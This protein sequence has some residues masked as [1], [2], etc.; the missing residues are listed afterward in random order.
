MKLC[1]VVFASLV[2]LACQT[3]PKRIVLAPPSPTQV[4]LVEPDRAEADEQ[5]TDRE[6]S[7]GEAVE[8]YLLKRT[9][10]A[11]LPAEKVLSARRHAALMPSYSVSAGRFVS[12]RAKNAGSRE[13]GLGT[14]QP[15]GPG[16][17]GG[18]TRALVIRP[19]D[20]NTMYA[21]SVGGGVWKTT[22]GGASW[23]PLTDLLP[24][25]GIG[26]LVMDPKNPD[27]L[28]AGTGEWFT[29]STRGDSIRGAGIYKTTDGGATWTLLPFTADN[30][31][32]YYVNKLVISPNDSQHVYAATYGGIWYSANAGTSW[33]RVLDRSGVAYGCQDLVTRTDQTTDYLFAGCGVRGGINP[34][35]YRN[36][37]AAGSGTWQIVFT[38][39]NMA[40]AVLGLAPSNQSIIYAAIVS[41][42]T[43]EYSN[44]LLGVYRSDSN[45]DPDS[46]TMKTSNQDA[47]LLNRV[48][49]S[50][51]RDFFTDVCSNGPRTFSNQGEYDN[52]IAVDPTNPDIVWVGGIDLFRS[53][54]GGANWGIAAFWEAAAPFL[55]HADN[56]AIVFAPGYNGADNQTLFAASDGG[57]Y[58]TDN[59]LAATAK[60]PRAACTPYSSQIIWQN[61]NNG[62]AVTQ[63]YHGSVYPG[64][65]VYVGGTQD[66]GTVRGSD[67]AGPNDW[68]NPI[69]G[70]GGVTAIDP[71]DPNVWYGETTRLTLRKTVNGGGTFATATRGITE[72]STNFQFI[73]PFVIDPS[74]PKRLYLG[75][76]TLWRTSDA[77]ANWSE[78][79][80]PISTAAGSISTIAVSGADPNHVVFGTSTGFIY[81]N[82]AALTADKTT[83]WQPVQPRT[84]YVSNLAFD[85]KDPNL[86]YATYS[87]YKTGSQN[88]V[89]KSTDGGATWTGLDGSG[90]TA[91]P[92]IPVFSIIVDPKNTANL[93]LG[94]DIGV[95]VSVDGG[96]TWARDDNPFA[97]AVTETLVLDH[98]TGQSVLVAF[99]HGRGVWKTVLPGSGDPCQVSLSGDSFAFPALGGTATF[100]VTAPDNCPWS[101]V[102]GGTGFTISSPAG[103]KGNGSF[104]I[105]APRNATT[106]GRSAKVSVQTGGIAVTQDAA[107][108]ASGNDVMA[109]PFAITGPPA[110]VI[111]NTSSATETTGDPVHTCTQSADS[112][113]LWFRVTAAD[114]GSLQLGFLNSRLDTGTDAGTVLTA[115][116]LVSGARGAEAVCSVTPQSN[117]VLTIRTPALSVQ[118][119]ESVLIE[120]SAT[121]F[122]A[123]AGAPVR[124][125]NLQLLLNL[126]K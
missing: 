12:P 45:G 101:A 87:Q 99:T 93:Y 5:E 54:D 56:H 117:S 57:V 120:V 53:D 124:P 18:R 21:G 94:T 81:R 38:S 42:E 63:F 116:R 89:Y 51:P 113:T 106:Q 78:A 108:A 84:G 16:N 104:T 123:P 37:D 13:A 73:T 32:F 103:G 105:T 35:I 27:T 10:G 30:S 122:N 1:V 2:L 97:D 22:D 43:G 33:R 126:V 15:L 24:S 40:D 64:G 69:G 125:G 60:G 34:G 118:A 55:S 92:D 20:P 85:P 59:A 71:T 26:S 111:E 86:V 50:N 23:N 8:F 79:S 4:T 65:G 6:D 46:W 72:A 25:I 100:R 107:V 98:S 39:E 96:A 70:D 11:P 83:A 66:N 115:Y 36:T 67:A 49:F 17:I 110:V 14:W 47:N 19:D 9:G 77:T 75:G 58:R 114:A 44:A 68:R 62:Y 28:Y 112:K 41:G 80:A 52:A 7:A 102:P 88:H 76:H 90:S 74:E 31:S 91:L 109:T 119:G 121:A 29:G 61:V 3:G 82:N 48:L 95:F